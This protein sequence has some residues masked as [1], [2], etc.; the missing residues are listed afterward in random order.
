[1]VSHKIHR[2]NKNTK[3][4]VPSPDGDTVF[5]DI[6]AC[7]LQV[8]T[9]VPYLFITCLDYELRS[10]LDL[11]KEN[12]F[13]QKKERSRWYPARF[14][15]DVDYA[16]DIALPATPPPKAESLLH[17]LKREAGGV[18]LN[19]NDEKIEYMCSNQNQTSDI[20]ILRDSALKL[21]NKFTYLGSCFSST[22]YDINTQLA[23]IW[24]AIDRQ[25]VISI[26]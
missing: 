26:K 13:T 20:S 15:I 5:F 3:V 18:G 7:V 8:D 1:M 16:D 11:M 24:S 12:G 10:L 22:E 14:I 6:I 17:S 21:V 23:K 9:L 2:C 4:K 25:S 19:F